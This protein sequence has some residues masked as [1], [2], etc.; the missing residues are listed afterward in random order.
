MAEEETS[1]FD[2]LTSTFDKAQREEF[3]VWGWR[4]GVPFAAALFVLL[5]LLAPKSVR[6]NPQ[7]FRNIAARS[8][9]CCGPFMWRLTAGAVWFLLAI[10]FGT[11]L[12]WCVRLMVSTSVWF[13]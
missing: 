8:C 1:V 5:L 11:L 7:R 2:Q 3:A 10:T 13:Q 6:C 12:A 4:L 9:G